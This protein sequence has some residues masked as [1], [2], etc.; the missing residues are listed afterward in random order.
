MLLGQA[1]VGV[2]SEQGRRIPW[3]GAAGDV[4][5]N[6]L[7]ARQAGCRRVC[8]CVRVRAGGAAQAGATAF[9]YLFLEDF[10]QRLR[11]RLLF[12]GLFQF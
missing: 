2:G 5:G 12:L 6:G 3:S 7:G 1:R 9:T 11:V 8:A 4:R 10:E